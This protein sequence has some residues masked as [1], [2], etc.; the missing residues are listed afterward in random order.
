MDNAFYSSNDF[1]IEIVYKLSATALFFELIRRPGYFPVATDSSFH[2][3]AP[4]M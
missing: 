1:T 3:S 4:R 2:K